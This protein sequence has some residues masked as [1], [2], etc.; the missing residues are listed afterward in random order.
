MH[1][2]DETKIDS[3]P[4][5]SVTIRAASAAPH[6]PQARCPQSNRSQVFFFSAI[7]DQ[8][9]AQAIEY[10][11]L[12][13]LAEINDNLDVLLPDVPA[14]QAEDVA[15]HRYRGTI[16]RVPDLDGRGAPAGTERD[17]LVQHGNPLD[18]GECFYNLF[19]GERAEDPDPEEPDLFAGFPHLIDRILDGAA[20]GAHGNDCGFCIVKTVFFDECAVIP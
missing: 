7:S 19:D 1:P 15:F 18:V 10:V 16:H 5:A 14:A 13:F 4:A 20:H 6:P 17:V 2:V 11:A 9:L 12:S 8:L 3:G